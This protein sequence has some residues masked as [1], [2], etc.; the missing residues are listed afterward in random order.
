MAQP[1]SKPMKVLLVGGMNYQGGTVSALKFA[2]TPES[3]N[4]VVA[5][6]V[7]ANGEVGGSGQAAGFLSPRV[8]NGAGANCCL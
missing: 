2:P 4:E 5:A 8:Q 6:P 3:H 7:T 1:L